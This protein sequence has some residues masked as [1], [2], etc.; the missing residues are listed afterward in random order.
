MTPDT[1]R[2]LEAIVHWV[3]AGKLTGR[4]CLDPCRMTIDRTFTTN[5]PQVESHHNLMIRIPE[6]F[7]SWPAST[8]RIPEELIEA[9]ARRRQEIGWTI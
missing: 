1:S 8:P 6:Q 9:Y 4:R 2:K 7:R 5:E 3:K